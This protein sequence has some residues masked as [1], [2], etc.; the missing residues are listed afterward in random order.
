LHIAAD[1]KA[2][3]M[4]LQRPVS[5]RRRHVY[6]CDA[7]C[8][9]AARVENAASLSVLVEDLDPEESFALLSLLRLLK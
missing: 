7:G 9:A 5:E 4:M 2:R 8:Q 1:G 3:R 6:C